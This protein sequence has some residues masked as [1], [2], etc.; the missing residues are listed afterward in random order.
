MV[1]LVDRA[2]L[3]VE[4]QKREKERE[5]EKDRQRDRQTDR[6]KGREQLDAVYLTF[7]ALYR[8]LDWNLTIL[9]NEEILYRT[10][11]EIFYP[12]R[13]ISKLL[14]LEWFFNPFA[15]NIFVI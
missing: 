6:Q 8:E 3:Y 4:L 2:F 10:I 5:R 14:P 11:I 7:S 1:V 15:L 12:V 9:F 13:W